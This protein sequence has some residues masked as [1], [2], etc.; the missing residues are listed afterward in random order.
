MAGRVPS[1]CFCYATFSFLKADEDGSAHIYLAPGV[2]PHWLGINES[3]GISDA[4][5]VFGTPFG[6]RL[7]HNQGSKTVT[8]N[9]LQP[10]LAHVSFVYPCRFGAVTS[11][12]ANGHP[13]PVTGTDVKLPAGTTQAAIRY[14]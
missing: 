7:T 9:I 6:F 14:L 5:T 10:P 2:M 3:I 13:V 1:L 8:L 4:P 12:T 11:I